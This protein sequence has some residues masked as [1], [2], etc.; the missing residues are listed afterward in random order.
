MARRDGTGPR[1]MGPM[2]GRGFGF[3]NTDRGYGYGPV[4]EIGRGYRLGR[5]FGRRRGYCFVPETNQ[6]F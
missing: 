6:E 5:N 2:T 3:C 4:R 1:G